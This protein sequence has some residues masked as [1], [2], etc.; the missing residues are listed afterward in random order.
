MCINCNILPIATNSVHLLVK[1]EVGREQDVGREQKVEREQDVDREQEV[2]WEQ[3]V[4]RAQE[5]DR[6]QEE[7]SSPGNL[8]EGVCPGPV[9]NFCLPIVCAFLIK[10][11]KYV[12]PSILYYHI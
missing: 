1:R 7:A 3:E 9:D 10:V 6:E 8:E 4:D 11:W 2:D 12:P 5:V